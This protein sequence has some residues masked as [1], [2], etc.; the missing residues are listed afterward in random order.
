MSDLAKK[1]IRIDERTAQTATPRAIFGSVGELPQ[2]IV[3]S[4][5]YRIGMWPCLHTDD[6]ALAMGIWGAL[7]Y[8]LEHW[9]DIRVYRLFVQ[10]DLESDFN[11]FQ[12]SIE[13]SQ[14]GL[15]DWHLEELDEN[16]AMW[17]ELKV[18]DDQCTLTVFIEND[19]VDDEETEQLNLTGSSVV[20]LLQ[21]LPEFAHTLADH[22]D[23]QRYDESLS[24]YTVSDALDVSA[25]AQLA[26]HVLHWDASLLAMLAGYDWE[27]ED[28]LALYRDMLNTGQA[29][30]SD[31]A[32]WLIAKSIAQTMRPGYSLIG[33]LMIDEVQTIIDAFP[34]S[35]HPAVLLSDGLYKLGYTQE[36]F[37]FLTRE[38]QA[39]PTST[40]AWLKY[41]ELLASSG[42]VSEAV[43]KF[44][45]AIENEAANASLYFIYG[46]V[47]VAA[48]RYDQ[49]IES[50][51][52]IDIDEIMTQRIVWEAV[53]A[54][55]E[56]I[57]LRP[58]HTRALH[59]QLNQLATLN[60][61][62]NRFWL[63]FD[64]L[65]T[66]DDTGALVRDVI[67]GL[68][69]DMDMQAGFSI[70]KQAIETHPDRVDLYTNLAS[71][72]L[73]SF[74]P[75]EAEEYLIKAKALT[76]DEAALADI[77]RLALAANDPEFEYRFG[78]LSA[79]VDAGNKLSAADVAYL[80]D[81][82][83]KAPHMISGHLTLSR[84]Y[85]AWGDSDA[86]IEVLLDVQQEMPDHP[87]V[88]DLLGQL[89]WEADERALAF[90]Y[91]NR[92][93]ATSPLYVPILTRIGRYL[94]ENEQYAESR[95]FLAYA[96]D[97]APNDP[98][99]SSVRTYIAQRIE[100]DPGKYAAIAEDE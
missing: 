49:P 84:A 10:L 42:R 60:D 23:A 72:Y 56:A 50:F 8:I 41:G 82:A 83:E 33:D 65:V 22:I 98:T 90:E 63:G 25:F 89:L 43:D 96:E 30:D 6:P 35:R 27:D 94:F 54:Y 48:Q 99:L 92:G 12:W 97:I 77:E 9:R 45:S 31:L 62:T 67:D 4:V 55:E 14:F 69:D 36:S 40:A 16:I 87:G 3:S 71:L 80:E 73:A 86:A 58:D 28:V 11:A 2:S 7:G 78:E 70:L 24:L 85:A 76:N 17:G 75:D 64:R 21:K 53:E 19:L 100:A 93:V 51:I 47:L 74:D 18:E 39:H 44:Q 13:K 26:G 88:L 37:D 34:H 59:A 79:I 29:I 61:V 68:Y 15:D 95:Q 52:L 5:P 57:K 20:D 91:L 1:L 38:T 32:G 66:L 46:N 81:I